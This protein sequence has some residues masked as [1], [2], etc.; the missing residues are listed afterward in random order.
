[1]INKVSATEFIQLAGKFKVIDVRSPVEFSGGH[2]SGAANIP[3]FTDDERSEV[4]SLYHKKGRDAAVLKGLDIALPKVFTYI[5][6]LKSL[7]PARSVCIH[8]WRGGMRSELMAEVFSRE[9]YSV[10]ILNGGYKAYRS[11]IRESF[12]KQARIVVLGGLTGSGKTDILRSLAGMGE[13][14]IDLERLASHKGSAFGALGQSAQPANEQFENDL[15]LTWN[16]LDF[17]KLIWMEDESRRIGRIE[18][19]SPFFGQISKGILIRAEVAKSRRIE[20]LVREYSGFPKQLLAESLLKIRDG[21]GGT[22]YRESLN[23][24]EEDDFG[25]V[26]SLALEYYDKA[27]EYSIRKRLNNNILT[28]RLR[29][30]DPVRHAWTIL[31]FIKKNL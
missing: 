31:R 25:K 6:D 9:R 30:S 23:A 5:K 21:L 27:Y 7:G 15:F 12:S 10:F 14:V 29:G 8:C 22:R 11:Y 26:A 4:G 18:L 3:L 17:N 24:L 20:R 2:I 1:M 19:P 16:R 28:V 13:Q